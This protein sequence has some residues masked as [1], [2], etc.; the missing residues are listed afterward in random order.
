LVEL[1]P[2]VDVQF[3]RCVD[4]PSSPLSLLD[5]EDGSLPTDPT[6]QFSG[7]DSST[8]DSEDEAVKAKRQKLDPDYIPST[9][10]ES[11]QTGTYS[12]DV[13]EDD[14]E[15]KEEEYTETDED[16]SWHPSDSTEPEIISSEDDDE[17]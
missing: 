13:S 2:E 9:A 8:S 3:G 14:R 1:N 10:S 17:L 16:E 12:Q 6:I 4:L 5:Q 11:T 15:E 7:S